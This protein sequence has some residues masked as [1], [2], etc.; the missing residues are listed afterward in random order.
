M[1]VVILDIITCA[2][3]GTEIFRGY[4][5]TAGRIFGFPIDSCVGL[6]TVQ[7]YCAACDMETRAEMSTGTFSVI[8][9]A[10]FST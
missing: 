2:K 7:R 5:F 4:D 9:P 6:T 1:V 3:F 8:R 10:K